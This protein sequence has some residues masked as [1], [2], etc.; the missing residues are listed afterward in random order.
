MYVMFSHTFIEAALK[1]KNDDNALCKAI[2]VPINNF[3]ANHQNA[4]DMNM[5]NQVERDGG[6]SAFGTAASSVGNNRIGT[7]SGVGSH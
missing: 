6:S 7:T 2:N 4:F 1:A 5:M 3:N